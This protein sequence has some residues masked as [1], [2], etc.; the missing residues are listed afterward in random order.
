MKNATLELNKTF[1]CWNCDTTYIDDKF[2]DTEEYLSHC[3]E[4]NS[5][6]CVVV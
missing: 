2:E 5:V 4:C 6:L 1:K 3:P